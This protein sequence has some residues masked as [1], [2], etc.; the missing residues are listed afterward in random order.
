[1]VRSNAIG[2]GIDAL[3]VANV[4]ICPTKIVI[5]GYNSYKTGIELLFRIV[6]S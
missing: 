4:A 5:V 1:M 2:P 3:I 6:R